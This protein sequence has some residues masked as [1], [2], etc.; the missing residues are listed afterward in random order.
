MHSKKKEFVEQEVVIRM[1]KEIYKK[2]KTKRWGGRKLYSII[3]NSLKTHNIKMG[4]DKFFDLLRSEGMLVKPRKRNYFTTDSHHW[5]HKYDYLIDGLELT[6][7]NQLW[8]S[9]ITYVESEDAA[10]YLYLITDAYSKMI[11]GWYISTNLKA[12][13]AVE[14]LKMALKNNPNIGEL[15]HHSDRG[16][17]YCSNEYVKI[18]NKNSIKISMTH[19]A[20]PQQ[21]AIAE[22][23]NGILKNEWLN[24]FKLKDVKDAK[25]KLKKIIKIYNTVRPHQTLNYSIPSEVHL[26]GFFRHP[27]ESI[28]IGKQ[29][30]YKKK[31]QT[32]KA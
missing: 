26:K 19:G 6:A 16:V 11:V 31:V 10:L 2:S 1:V 4:R 13:S 9:D 23:I 20:S 21:N 27:I 7:P 30:R 14:A 12:D 3:S 25:R 28:I 18:L 32:Q 15:I 29:Y 24:D 8:V 22:R 17:Q 5:L